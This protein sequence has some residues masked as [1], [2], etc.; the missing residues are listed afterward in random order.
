MEYRRV[1]EKIGGACFKRLIVDRQVIK[2]VKL[3]GQLKGAL[4][5]EPAEME[6]THSEPMNLIWIMPA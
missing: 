2:V 1:S 5:I 4:V 6:C 3:L